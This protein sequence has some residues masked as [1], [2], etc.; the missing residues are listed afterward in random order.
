MESPTHADLLDVLQRNRISTVEVADALMKTGV[1]PGLDALN[2][3]HY[4]AGNV[5]YVYTHSESNWPLHEQIANVEEGSI[6]YVDTFDCGDRAVLGDIVSKYLFVYKR[7]SAL[8]I[9]GLARDAH[10]LKKE[11]YPIWLRGVTPLGCFNKL[12]QESQSLQE[13]VQQR[14][15]LFEESIL[16]CDDSGVTLI[17]NDRI[18]AETYR[19]LE[20]IE[21]QEDIWY[22]CTDVLKWSTYET[23]CQKKYLENRELLPEV[24]LKKL[25]HYES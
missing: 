22:F 9:N 2:E 21:L 11:N 1:Q 5:S 12:V 6:L 13:L 10:R 23:I 3:G 15:K 14:R 25:E 18:N 17:G 8:V 24:L 20:F 16:V 7:I 19:R 4:A